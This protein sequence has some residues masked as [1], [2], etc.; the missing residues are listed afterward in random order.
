MH[1]YSEQMGRS[2][3]VTTPFLDDSS[4][5]S[6]YK[7]RG[8]TAYRDSAMDEYDD[9]SSSHS[10]ELDLEILGEAPGQES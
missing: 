10:C 7:R 3:L 1:R 8:S 6:E 4:C 2:A 5:E 9:Q